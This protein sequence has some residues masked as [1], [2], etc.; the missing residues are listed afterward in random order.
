MKL[1][2]IL[3]ACLVLAAV[4]PSSL[5]H[6]PRAAAITN[7]QGRGL[8]RFTQKTLH[9]PAVV[10]RI[11]QLRAENKGMARAMRD[12]ERK[13]LRPAFDQSVTLLEIRKTA[14]SRERVNPFVKASFQSETF[15]EDGYEMT[16]VSYDD[17]DPNTWEG[18]IYEHDPDGNEYEYTA[19]IDISGEQETWSR[20][21]E[22]YYP[23]DGSQP[24]SSNDPSYYDGS[25][26]PNVPMIRSI[27]RANSL[28]N[29]TK[30]FQKTSFN[31]TTQLRGPIPPH[32]RDRTYRWLKCSAAGCTTS[33]I[34]CLIS[35]PLWPKCF[36]AWC[37]G[38][39]A[40]CVIASW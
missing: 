20:L 39:A 1:F 3:M 8:D 36:A 37:G 35:G 32:W 4:V 10:A 19:S 18:V 11:K 22:T 5:I 12:L 2:L 34:G 15:S 33:A 17:G 13:G 27:P 23:W 25:Y 24:V 26:Q 38:S 6:S 16:F 14:V 28:G 30:V 29:G 40:G 9:G 21:E 7:F 31:T